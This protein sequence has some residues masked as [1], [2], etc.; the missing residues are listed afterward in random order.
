MIESWSIPNESGFMYIIVESAA[1]EGPMVGA[2]PDNGTRR[3][4]YD[5]S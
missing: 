2:F 5:K 1:S 4:S 3:G